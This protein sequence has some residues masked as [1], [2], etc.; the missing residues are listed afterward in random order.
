MSVELMKELLD[1]QSRARRDF[2]KRVLRGKA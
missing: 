2:L 1:S